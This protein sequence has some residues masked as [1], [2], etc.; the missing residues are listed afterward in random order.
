M[1]GYEAVEPGRGASGRDE[2]IWEVWFNGAFHQSCESKEHAFTLSAE[3]NLKALLRVLLSHQED[4]LA[5]RAFGSKIADIR[6]LVEQIDTGKPIKPAGP[7]TDLSL[8]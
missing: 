3:L 8:G 1:S 6:A 2:D 7:S 5:I 4:R